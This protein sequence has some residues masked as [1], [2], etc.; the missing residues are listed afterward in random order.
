M[1][2]FNTSYL[3]GNDTAGGWGSRYFFTFY[4]EFGDERAESVVEVTVLMV[5]FAASFVANVYIAWAVLRYR[6]MRTVT[7]CFLLNLTVADLL[8]AVTAPALAYVR[9]RPDWPFG[10]FACRLLPY[11]QLVCGFV[12]LWTLMLISMDRYR[13]I[14]VPPYRSQLTPRRA[15][16]LTVLTWLIALAVFMPVPFWFHEQV[17]M[18]RTAVKLCTLVFPKN[19]TFKMSVA[20]TV[21]VVSLSCVLPLS[22]FVYHYQRIFHKLNKTRRRIENSVS[23]PSV[24]VHTASLNSLSPPTDGSTPQ[25]FMR[26]EEI[27]YRKHVRVVRVLLINVIVVLVMWLPIT[28]VM[29]MIYVDGSRDTEDTGYFLRSHHFIMGL[30]FALLNTVVNP[31][32]YGVL[33]K[34]FRKCL[35]QLSFISKRRRIM[36]KEL[37]NSRKGYA[38]TPSNGHYNSTQQPGSSASVIEL[39]ATAVVSSSTTN[40]CWR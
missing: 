24:A 19:D 40:E 28:V 9:V 7:N 35:A 4:S 26:H 10:D 38:R 20:F 13:C 36:Y 33:S 5:I 18:G 1:S 14:V 16:V 2:L 6:E 29:C 8:F 32:L 34:N 21:P 30:L 3:M 11:S 37:G 12:L 27:R 17:V 15:T 23:Q 31:I 22:L 25:V 39:P